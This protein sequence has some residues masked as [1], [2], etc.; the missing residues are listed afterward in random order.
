M[1]KY[2]I[3]KIEENRISVVILCPGNFM[4]FLYDLEKE[5]NRLQ[6]EDSEVIIDLFLRHGLDRRF[7]SIPYRNS[8]FQIQFINRSSLSLEIEK[9]F[10]RFILANLEIL[11]LGL[12]SQGQQERIL[13]TIRQRI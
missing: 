12:L 1:K 6:I 4:D 3:I 9:F 10:N 13:K 8:K 2:K 11:K 7:F 5:I